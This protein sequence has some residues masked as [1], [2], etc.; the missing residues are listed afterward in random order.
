M[1]KYIVKY[2]AYS[3]QECEVEVEADSPE[4]AE[5]IAT[6]QCDDEGYDWVPDE[7]YWEQSS[8]VEEKND[9]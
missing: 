7:C 8:S 6:V 3:R 9:N 5:D 1:G 4:E 2:V